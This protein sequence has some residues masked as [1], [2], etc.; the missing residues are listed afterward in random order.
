MDAGR[1]ADFGIGAR[2]WAVSGRLVVGGGWGRAGYGWQAAALKTW[3]P[4][5]RGGGGG[6]APKPRGGGD[7]PQGFTRDDSPGEDE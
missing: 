4:K 1:L 7:F 5:H 2:C 6:Q 3:Q